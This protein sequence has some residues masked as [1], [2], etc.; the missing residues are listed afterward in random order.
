M[1]ESRRNVRSGG[2]GEAA[3]EPPPHVF[4][5]R[6]RDGR[7]ASRLDPE[8]GAHLMRALEAAGEAL[9]RSDA[10]EEPERRRADALGLLAERGLAAG[11]GAGDAPVSGSRADRT[12]VVVRVD[13]S[14]LSGGGESGQS[15]L[16]DGTRVSAETSRRMACDASVVPITHDAAGQTVHVSRR[17]RTV[18]TLLRR[19]LEARDRGC[20]FPGCGLR[21][22][23][24]HHIH[25]WAQ[26]G[27][28]NLTNVVL[29]CRRH[30]RAVHEGGVSV[31]M[32]RRQQ[33]VFFTP[34]G[35]RMSAAPRFRGNVPLLPE[36][37]EQR[38]RR[39][40]WD[41]ASRWKRDGHIPW[42]IETQAWAALECTE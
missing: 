11:F 41:C 15:E 40:G 42:R 29:L 10:E 28:T 5:G 16:D 20:R 26:G 4:R 1:A 6:G 37:G 36:P 18:P 2:R 24:A 35:V 38:L 19:A 23:E 14:T 22:T 9:F 13:A 17:T 7:G 31:C 21:F 30:H 34:A 33:V 27:E 3:P 39:A 8:N 25:H 32:D 12:Q